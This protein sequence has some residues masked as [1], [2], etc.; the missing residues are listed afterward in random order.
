V[1]N[2]VR[3][4]YAPSPTG[5]PHVGNIRTALFNWLF[6]RCSGGKFIVRIEDT[7]RTRY[8]EGATEA[9]LDSLKWLGLDWDEGPEVGGQ[10]K[11][12]YQSERLT[13]YRAAAEQLVTED[14]AYYCYCT[15]DRLA[16]M[17]TEQ[18]EKKQSPGYDRRCRDLTKKEIA[19][20][21]ASNTPKVIRFKFPVE[22]KTCF[23]DLIRGDVKFENA[24]IDDF[25]ILKSDGYPTYHL[26]SVVDDHLMKISHILRGEEWISSTPK[27]IRLNKA[28]GYKPPQFAHLPMILGKDRSKLSKRHGTV[29]II[30]YKKQGYL[31]E[32]LL[33]FLA[34]LG[35][36]LDDK[37]EIF[38]KDELIKH[39]S[40]EKVS[41]TAA[42]FNTEK[43]EWMNGVYIRNLS[44]EELTEQ[45]IPILERDLPVEVERPLDKKLVALITPLVK[46]RI[47]TLNGVT[48]IT[49]FFFS[50]DI[51]HD[52]DIFTDKKT[53]K[54][55]AIRVLEASHNKLKNL[56]DFSE[57]NL[58]AVLRSLVE[59]LGL[60]AGQLFGAIRNAVTG[61][62]VTPPLFGTMAVLG[63]ERCLERIC[64]ALTRL[65]ETQI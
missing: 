26:A 24:G 22:E 12:Y 6:A 39:F 36:A 64:K 55:T 7:D 32:A 10:F 27:H 59:E 28:L 56:S 50:E 14:K 41:K 2:Q 33:N 48:E 38:N 18:A 62:R 23:E 58:E 65:N 4:R 47:K 57:V 34:L 30:D 46:E 61:K 15:P 8:T 21:E 17:R 60:K 13:E 37:T 31:P 16:E 42:I 29:S 5:L 35:W 3:V 40:L 25:V 51:E 53:D 20:K 54:S 44:P 19:E 1:T 63:K 52:I 43:L 49:D 45:L 11:P 9:I